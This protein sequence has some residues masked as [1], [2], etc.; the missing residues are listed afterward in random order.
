MR[1]EMCNDCKLVWNVSV[2]HK[3]KVYQCP[4]CEE[5]AKKK[6]KKY[7]NVP[8]VLNKNKNRFSA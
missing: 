1:Y 3:G 8:K 6:A 7:G 2:K 4:I 5:K